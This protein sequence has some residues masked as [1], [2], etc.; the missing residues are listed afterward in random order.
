MP[1]MFRMLIVA[2]GAALTLTCAAGVT[3][4]GDVEVTVGGGT[5]KVTGS[6]AD[7]AVTIAAAGPNAASVT[8]GPGTT[9]NGSGV[10]QVFGGITKAFK[11]KLDDGAD[12]LIITNLNIPA[13]VIKTGAGVDEV[14]FFDVGISDKATIDLGADNNALE[15]CSVDLPKTTIKAGAPNG[16]QV[17]AACPF[18]DPFTVASDAG[19]AVVIDDVFVSGD[20][21]MKMGQGVDVAGIQFTTVQGNAKVSMGADSGAVGI[22]D[23]LVT[24]NLTVGTGKPVSGQVTNFGC[25]G[26]EAVGEASIVLEE[27]TVN[28]ALKLKTSGG[29]DDITLGDVFAGGKSTL[30]AGGGNNEIRITAVT[31]NQELTA[32]TGKGGDFYDIDNLLVRG[33]AKITLGAGANELESSNSTAERDLTVKGGKNN[34][35]IDTSGIAVFGVKKVDGGG[36]FDTITE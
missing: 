25:E 21:A 32:K 29:G 13:V 31:L 22:C 12:D 17:E 19:S 24:G 4:A 10:L 7:D 2:I 28:G 26:F 9:I 16:T 33:K 36:G 20:L 30:D 1:T 3:L 8:P 11:I 34:D 23:V 27:T 5:L 15:I 18:V 35:T 6:P 14:Q